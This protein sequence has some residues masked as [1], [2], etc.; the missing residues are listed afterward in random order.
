M[1]PL[2]IDEL[3]DTYSLAIQR[4]GSKITMEDPSQRRERLLLQDATRAISLMFHIRS[5]TKDE[6]KKRA[7]TKKAA[8]L[9][10]SAMSNVETMRLER[11]PFRIE[12]ALQ[13]RERDRLLMQEHYIEGRTG[14]AEE[15]RKELLKQKRGADEIIM[16]GF[17]GIENATSR[18][19]LDERR[20]QYKR[21]Q[22]I[23]GVSRP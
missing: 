3:Y 6:K 16:R 10:S 8:E 14:Q 13:E 7:I 2:P 18:K 17:P 21:A 11:E 4:S 9:A 12:K 19:L 1:R 20:F 15:I 22:A 5:M 23:R